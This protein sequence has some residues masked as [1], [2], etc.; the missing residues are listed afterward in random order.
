LRNSDN[1]NHHNPAYRHSGHGKYAY[2]TGSEFLRYADLDIA[3]INR[4]LWKRPHIYILP[5]SDIL[6]GSGC[7]WKRYELEWLIVVFPYSDRQSW[8]ALIGIMSFYDI[9]YGG[10]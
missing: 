7:K 4:P 2:S 10:G 5:I 9:L 6:H 1:C 8:W 3:I